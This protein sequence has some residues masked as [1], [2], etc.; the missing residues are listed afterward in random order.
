VD[1]DNKEGTLIGK[2]TLGDLGEREIIGRLLKPRYDRLGVSFGD[3]CAWLTVERSVDGVWVAS[4]DPCPMPMAAI[5]GFTD[6]YYYGWLLGTINLSDLA[7]AGAAPVGVLSSLVLPSSMR[8]SDFARLL[9]GLD[10][11]C[12]DAGTRV[13]GGNLKEGDK[14]DLTAT[15]FGICTGPEPLGRRGAEIGDTVGVIGGFGSFWAG[16]FLLQRHLKV[17]GKDREAL[18]DSVLTPRPMVSVGQ[19]LRELRL[20]SACLDNSDGLYPSLRSLC[21][22]SNVGIALRLEDVEYDLSVREVAQKMG[23]DPARFALGWGDWQLIITFSPGKLAGIQELCGGA[24]IGFR[25]IGTVTEGNGVTLAHG[26][27]V[28]P[29]LALDSQRFTP[30]SWFTKGLASYIATLL[31]APLTGKE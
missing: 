13:V 22:S 27:R 10:E 14:V 24:G 16:V 1:S 8:V 30:D 28:G 21:E 12:I 31:D 4:T 23:V 11:C 15:A 18:I 26:G 19:R 9:D 6:Y 25:A 7:A 5:L 29:L 2:E 17:V 3:D 20:V